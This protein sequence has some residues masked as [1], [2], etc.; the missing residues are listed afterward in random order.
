MLAVQIPSISVTA[1]NPWARNSK[2]SP[3]T[4]SHT[5]HKRR[6]VISKALAFVPY[7][8]KDFLYIY[9]IP[10]LIITAVKPRALALGIQHWLLTAM[11]S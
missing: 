2:N 5:H 1:Q 7:K 6:L 8:G 3:T 9:D 10:T 4:F 11:L